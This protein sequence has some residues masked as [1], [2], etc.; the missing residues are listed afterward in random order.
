MHTTSTNYECNTARNHR[1][2]IIIEF[3]SFVNTT[4]NY[5]QSNKKHHLQVRA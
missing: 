1:L 5:E 4:Q 2:V 3:V